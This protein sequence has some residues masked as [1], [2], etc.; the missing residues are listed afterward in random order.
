LLANA[1][2][3]AQVEE[4]LEKLKSER[5]MGARE[6]LERFTTVGRASLGKFL[7]GEGADRYLD[8]SDA[9]PADLETLA[10]LGIETRTEV[11]DDG[12]VVEVTKTRIK[13]QPKIEALK[14]MAKHHGLTKPAEVTV[15][16]GFAERLAQAY[17]RVE[18]GR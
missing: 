2:V 15:T 12:R 1:T 16:R 17:Q 5:I 9:T 6:T 4:A 3:W 8:F 10:E 11:G 7:R 14:A 18:D 13:L